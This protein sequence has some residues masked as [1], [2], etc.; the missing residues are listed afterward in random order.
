MVRTNKPVIAGWLDIV[1]GIIWLFFVV[2]LI[3]ILIGFSVGFGTP[4]GVTQGR[5]WLVSIT[6]AL[7]G[8]LAIAGGLFSIR[9]RNWM[10]ALIGSICVVPLGLGI[11]AVVLLAQSRNA[12]N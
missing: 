12:F 5:L 8:I 10:L 1:A 6:F 11:I 3:L 4:S 7:P 9:R 2:L